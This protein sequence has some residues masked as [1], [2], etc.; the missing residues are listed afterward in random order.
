MRLAVIALLAVV[1][2]LQAAPLR[3]DPLRAL[4]SAEFAL[5]AGDVAAAARHYLQAASVS[6]DPL[7]AERAARIALHADDQ[8]GAADALRRW[9]VLDPDSAALAQAEALLALAAGDAESATAALA[10]LMERPGSEGWQRA[11]QALA[12]QPGDGPAGPALQSLVRQDRL[13]AEPEAWFA[14]GGLAGRLG[15]D[16]MAGE[17]AERAVARFPDAPRVWLWQAQRR[18]LASDAQGARQAIDHAVSLA[19]EDTAVR[20]TAAAELDALGDSAAAAELL[21]QGPQDADTLLGRVAYLARGEDKAAMEALYR[22]LKE[23]PS[24]S[25]AGDDQLFLL[26]QLAELLERHEEALGWYAKVGGPERRGQAALRQSVALEA[27]DRLDQ[28]LDRLRELQASDSADG[29]SVRDAYLLEAELLLKRNRPDEA[30]AAYGRGLSIFED[31]PQL[32]YARA[33]ALA[34]L[35]RVAE[36]EQ[37]LQRL[38]AMDPDNADA[39][40]ALG[41]TLADSGERLEEARAYIERALALAPDSAAIID[42]LGW[43][44]FRMGDTA[45]AVEQLRRAFALQPDPEIAAHLGEAL[46]AAGEAEAA[47]AAWQQGLEL[48]RDNVVLRRTMERLDR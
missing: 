14:F 44:L 30:V 35:D 36:A 25:P 28:A 38:I 21:A 32:L 48:D 37:D 4:L 33:L 41:Y 20:L 8:T 9:R 24:T 12:G 40:N 23:Q 43:V 26:G 45:A 34:E 1:L 13:P 47:R 7:V 6:E 5:Q 3:T 29:Q 11:L 10:R 15:L 31:D 39:L 18:R 19:P 46:W 22:D 17:L 27:L 42:S 16:D 2:P